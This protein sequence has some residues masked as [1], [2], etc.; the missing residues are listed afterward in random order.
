MAEPFDNEQR[1]AQRQREQQEQQRQYLSADGL[2]AV[3]FFAI[4]VASEGGKNPY[5]L[6][7]AGNVR[8]GRMEPADNSGIT[9]GNLQ[10]D[11]GQRPAVA[12]ELV[13]AYQEWA[14]QEHPQDLLTAQQRQQAIA[15]LGRNGDAIRADNGRPM[16]AVVQGRIN[17]FLASESG[18]NFV[19]RHDSEEAQELALQAYRPLAA[20]RLYT[21]ATIDDQIRMATVVGKLHNQN[22]REAGRILE[23]A[24]NGDFRNFDQLLRV[25]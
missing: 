8:N 22:P 17:T 3:S 15:D 24:E 9:I 23:R 6:E 2:N 13:D 20:T 19:H 4:G 16:I 25:P 14:R 11:L 10:I 7:F 5:A 21:D 1:I 18:I 12:T